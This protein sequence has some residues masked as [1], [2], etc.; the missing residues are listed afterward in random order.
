MMLTQTPKLCST[1]KHW[2]RDSNIAPLVHNVYGYIEAVCLQK[3]PDYTKRAWR[4]GA[5]K[6][7]HWEQLERLHGKTS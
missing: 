2:C 5:D 6:C 4:R 3:D 7:M 1:C